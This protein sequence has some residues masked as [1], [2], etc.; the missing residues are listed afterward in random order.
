[1][2]HTPLI[3]SAEKTCA[4]PSQWLQ[5][6]QALACN[7]GHFPVDFLLYFVDAAGRCLTAVLLVLGTQWEYIMVV[8]M[9]AWPNSV[10]MVRMVSLACKRWVVL[11]KACHEVR[12]PQGTGRYRN[13]IALF[14]R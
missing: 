10:C 3:D 4:Q 2:R 7:A 9:L 8:L 14:H 11:F 6:F 12:L 13:R 5:T 1:M